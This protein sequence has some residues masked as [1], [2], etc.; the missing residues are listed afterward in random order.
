MLPAFLAAQPLP[1]RRRPRANMCAARGKVCMSAERVVDPIN[2]S[3]LG[4]PKVIAVG[5]ALFDRL[6]SDPDAAFDEH[7]KW[8]SYP[9]GAPMN[10]ASALAKL[11]TACAFVGGVGADDAGDSLRSG[12]TSAG[13]NVDGVQKF[14]DHPTRAVFVRHDGSGEG[15]FVG[16]SSTS[17]DCA[18]AQRLDGEKLPGVLFYAAQVFACGTLGLAFPGSRAT[19]LELADLA[20]VCRLRVFVDVNWRP[21]FWDGVCTDAEARSQI[22]DFL[23]DKPGAD[24]IKISVED[25]RF[26]LG[27][28]TAELGFEDPTNIIRAIGGKCQ[29]AIVTA[30]ERGAAWAFSIPGFDP[31]IGRVPSF[32]PPGG[33]A[34]DCT[35]AGDAFLAGFL[36][37][38]FVQG[39]LPSLTDPTRVK[40]MATFASA[41]AAHV[42]GEK[43]AVDPQPSRPQVDAFLELAAQK[44]PKASV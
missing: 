19:V 38:M 13:V 33:S 3:R 8:T 39:G 22:L 2:Q 42:V 15:R 36:S 5:E 28:K 10:L 17:V 24:F 44:S 6:T 7:E 37:E 21:V 41:V 43:G 40:H 34:V 14:T 27:E 32:A 23:C 30:G 12:L 31:V 1:L 25:A 35:G 20:H 18:D 4:A 9:G 11:D 26:L 16:Y 29:G